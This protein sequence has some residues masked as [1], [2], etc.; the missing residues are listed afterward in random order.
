MYDWGNK[1]ELGRVRSTHEALSGGAFFFSFSFSPS[2][3][4]SGKQKIRI[5]GLEIYGAY[6]AHTW[7]F[8]LYWDRKDFFFESASGCKIS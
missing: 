3:L 4:C 8:D 6:Y 7:L 2:F 5:C 1:S